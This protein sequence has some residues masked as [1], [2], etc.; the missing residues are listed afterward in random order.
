MGIDSAWILVG[1]SYF[2]DAHA[3]AK[4]STMPY[5]KH[6]QYVQKFISLDPT[7]QV[8]ERLGCFFLGFIVDL[9]AVRL[10]GI[11]GARQCFFF[12][13]YFLFRARG[14]SWPA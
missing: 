8:L 4:V 13:D 5:A 7:Y 12:F 10:F 9:L 6:Q 3:S 11:A 14:R 1:R 2:R